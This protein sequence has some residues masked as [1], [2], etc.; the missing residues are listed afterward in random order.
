MARLIP[1]LYVDT[2]SPGE[3]MIFEAF[4]RDELSKD[5]VV[6]HSLDMPKHQ[7]QGE[8][9]ID[10][11]VLIPDMGVLCLEVKASPNIAR[12]GGMWRTMGKAYRDPRGPFKQVKE[13]TFSL[14]RRVKSDHRE[15]SRIPFFGIVVF[16]ACRFRALTRGASD[17]WDD[18]DFIDS[19]DLARAPISKLLVRAFLEQTKRHKLELGDF[20]REKFDDMVG[21][22]RPD[23]E[24][25]LTPRERLENSEMQARRYTQEQFKILDGILLNERIVV[26]GLAGTG[27]TILAMEY[28]RRMSRKGLVLFLTPVWKLGQYLANETRLAPPNFVGSFQTFKKLYFSGEKLSQKFEN[29]FDYL[30]LDEAQ[31]FVES[32]AFNDFNSALKGGIENGKWIMF[33]DYYSRRFEN[34]QLERFEEFRKKYRPTICSLTQNCRNP[35]GLAKLVEDLVGFGKKYG[36]LMRTDSESGLK[37]DFYDSLRQQTSMLVDILNELLNSGIGAK[38]IA[39]LSAKNEEC[40]SPLANGN[41]WRNKMSSEI[42]QNKIVHAKVEDF[43]GLESDFVILTDLENL[44]TPEARRT[45]YLGA[46]RAKAGLYIL[47]STSLERKF[48]EAER[49]LD[50]TD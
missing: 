9:E 11:V 22:L 38:S 47:A 7:T 48:S 37:V 20:D 4:E 2:R 43:K 32:G 41:A 33:G 16:T 23:F 15:M 42:G 30:V 28:A 34:A 36:A 40:V 39:V 24:N 25:L 46:T 19:D 50:K 14:L 18:S 5:W 3:K 1:P 35:S 27:K 12:R 29:Y 17:E 44:D 31:D 49:N 45:F 13:N 6:F 26:D 21:I 10:F 8:G